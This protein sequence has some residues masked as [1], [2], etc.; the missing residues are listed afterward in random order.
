MAKKVNHLLI[1]RKKILSRPFKKNSKFIY[2]S[3]FPVL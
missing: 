3:P 2:N 1:P